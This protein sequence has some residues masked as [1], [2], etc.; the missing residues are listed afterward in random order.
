MLLNPLSLRLK[1]NWLGETRLIPR[2][3][4][5]EAVVVA[6]IRR[7]SVCEPIRLRRCDL[8]INLEL[9]RVE[10]IQLVFKFLCFR[11]NVGL[12]IFLEGDLALRVQIANFGDLL[13]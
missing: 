13:L 6:V 12:D 7:L 11:L 8:E 2:A 10:H 9:L 3:E 1:A 4:Q 5:P